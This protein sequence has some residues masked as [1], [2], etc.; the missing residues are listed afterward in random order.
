VLLLRYK[1]TGGPLL[2]ILRCS[3]EDLLKPFKAAGKDISVEQPWLVRV[4]YWTFG[5]FSGRA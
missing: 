3:W 2:L 5:T 4:E 1:L